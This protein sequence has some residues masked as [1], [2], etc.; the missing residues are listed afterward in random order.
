MLAH[1]GL[2]RPVPEDLS[3]QTA[4]LWQW[5]WVVFRYSPRNH[6]VVVAVVSEGDPNP[7]RQ[8]GDC[9]GGCP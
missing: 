7:C 9:V 8:G 2:H 3:P 4:W 6:A 5:P 1:G